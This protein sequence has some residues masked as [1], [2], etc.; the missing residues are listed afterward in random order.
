MRMSY[1]VEDRDEYSVVYLTGEVDLS[2][3]PSARKTIL[4]CL[5][6]NTNLLVDMS[7]VSYIDS[8]GVASLVEGYQLSRNLQL[9]FALVGVSAAA[10]NVLRLA[11]LDHVFPIYTSLD[12]RLQSG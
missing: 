2:C 5:Q 10:M 11:R 3:S 4:A 7:S 8:S 12:E 6:N 9:D 1:A